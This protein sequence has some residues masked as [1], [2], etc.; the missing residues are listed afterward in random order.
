L[1]H[2]VGINSFECMKICGLTNPKFIIN[3]LRDLSYCLSIGLEEYLLTYSVD[4]SLPW[5]ANRSQLG[6]KFPTFYGTGRFI[7]VFI[8][9]RHLS[10]SWATLIQSMPS[11]PTSWRSIL[12]LSSH[13]CLGLPKGLL[14]FPHQNPVSTSFL[15]HTC[16][17]PTHLILL[18]LEE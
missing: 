10:L 3:L 5:D 1:L 8:R 4:Q 12:I 14:R 18:D 9:V 17:M 7:T 2:L 11:H 13:L 6:K 15:P 16:Y